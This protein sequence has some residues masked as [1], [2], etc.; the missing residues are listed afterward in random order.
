[1]LALL[2]CRCREN[3]DCLA[4]WRQH[5]T[6]KKPIPPSAQDRDWIISVLLGP[7]MCLLPRPA[8]SSS[9]NAGWK[10]DYIV[11]QICRRVIHLYSEVMAGTTAG[12]C[13]PRSGLS[14][15]L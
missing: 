15:P 13:S 14:C 6:S 3:N 8:C 9:T 7:E 5:V 12:A 1:M 11:R 2:P 4:S 10:A